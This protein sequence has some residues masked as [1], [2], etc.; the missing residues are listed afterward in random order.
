MKNKVVKK[1]QP[2]VKTVPEPAVKQSKSPIK[3]TAKVSENEIIPVQ[4]SRRK[5]EILK[6]LAHNPYYEK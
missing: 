5:L 6:E 2:A 4:S 3:E 1:S